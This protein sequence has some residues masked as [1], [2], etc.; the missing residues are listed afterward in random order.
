MDTHP[1]CFV[2]MPITTPSSF[3]ELY[4][5]GDHFNHILQ[6]L[7]MPAIEKAGFETV[8]PKSTGSNLIHADI[9]SNLS[10]C[11]LVLCDMSIL[12]PN[13]FFEFGIRCALDKPI[14][15]VKDDKTE[16]IPFDT[17]IINFLTYHSIPTWNFSEEVERLSKHIKDSYEKSKGRNALWKYFGVDQI[18]A[19]S[20]ETVTPDDKLDFII[21]K[22]SENKVLI[23][24]RESAFSKLSRQEKHVLL[25]VSEGKTNRDIANILELSD[26]T[27]RNYVSSVL[28]KLGLSNRAEA[29]AYAISNGLRELLENKDAA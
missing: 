15:L 6:H 28:D 26:G 16:A 14:A 12:N 21:Q 18:G 1:K 7:F 27:T 9:I 3:V 13:V 10:N 29:A 25:L 23:D 22:L 19:F 24:P 11:E 5:D 17:G 4:N 2:I 8:S 20:P